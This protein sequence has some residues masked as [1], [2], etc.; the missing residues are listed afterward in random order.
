MTLLREK[1]VTLRKR[2]NLKGLDYFAFKPRKV[3]FFANPSCRAL[4]LDDYDCIVVRNGNFSPHC[5]KSM[6]HEMCHAIQNREGRLAVP[7]NHFTKLYA[8]EIE[9]EVFARVE[10]RRLYQEQYGSLDE[11]WDLADFVAYREFFKNQSV[12]SHRLTPMSPDEMYDFVKQ[13]KGSHKR[14]ILKRLRR[15]QGGSEWEKKLARVCV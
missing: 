4:Y 6:L 14:P 15:K 8:L 13:L 1:F 9:A 2:Y 11:E 12:E 7:K 10:Y 3:P 5:L